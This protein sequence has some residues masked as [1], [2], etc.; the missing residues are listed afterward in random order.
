VE[1]IT[2]TSITI[3]MD[4][5]RRGMTTTKPIT[6]THR[7]HLTIP[8]MSTEPTLITYM[9]ISRQPSTGI[10]TGIDEW[11]NGRDEF[12]GKITNRCKRDVVEGTVE[13]PVT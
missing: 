13:V 3:T 8:I 4:G 10:R 1:E 12:F 9:G 11:R 5:W 7:K 2:R 6:T